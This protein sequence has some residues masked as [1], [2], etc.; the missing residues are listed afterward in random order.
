MWSS[1]KG[2]WTERK[3]RRRTKKTNHQSFTTTTH[4]IIIRASLTAS[5]MLL[6][7]TNLLRRVART[8]KSVVRSRAKL[9]LHLNHPDTTDCWI[10]F[11]LLNCSASRFITI[12]HCGAMPPVHVNTR[13]L[14]S[15]CSTS[16]NALA[17]LADLRA[18]CLLEKACG[19]QMSIAS[20]KR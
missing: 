11:F 9:S 12:W 18:F 20:G 10:F 15:P 8:H 2:Q 7:P 4:S 6:S 16:Q 19:G 17:V 5:S 3:R 13:G 1:I 14:K